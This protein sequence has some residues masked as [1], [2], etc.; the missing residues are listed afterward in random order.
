M[1]AQLAGETRAEGGGAGPGTGP[2][3]PQKQDSTT[4]RSEKSDQTEK[5]LPGQTKQEPDGQP[6]PKQEYP[7]PMPVSR[8]LIRSRSFTTDIQ[9]M[10]VSCSKV[11]KNIWKFLKEQWWKFVIISIFISG[12]RRPFTRNSIDWFS[13]W[14][15]I[16]GRWRWSHRAWMWPPGCRAASRRTASGRATALQLWRSTATAWCV[17]HRIAWTTWRTWSRQWCRWCR[18]R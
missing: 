12:Q 18:P 13:R 1:G 3:P 5:A 9:R 16:W 6:I 10:W 11:I 15:A 8:R 7:Q 2:H 4:K 17:P 14:R